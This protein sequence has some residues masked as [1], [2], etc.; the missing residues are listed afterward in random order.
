MKALLL[1]ADGV[2]ITAQRFDEKY[3]RDFG[4]DPAVFNDFFKKE[5][6]H[7]IIG[8]KDLLETVT[9]WL[10]SWQWRGSA[11][12]FLNYWFDAE[13]RVDERVITRVNALK[14]KG[15]IC[16]LATNQEKYRTAY[17]R[18]KMGFGELFDMV[19][20]S[21]ELGSKKPQDLF[22]EK[23]NDDMRDRFGISPNEVLFFDDTPSHVE[24][25]RRH[26]IDS[27]LYDFDSFDKA[28]RM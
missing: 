10:D 11:R 1:D 8:E 5:F 23:I 6:N 12:E 22:F 2:V 24:A 14:T 4:V 13:S 9:P 7:C 16:C 18:D 3:H 15:V 27:R 26:G 25:A 28:T 21:C 20:S 19:Y 17:L